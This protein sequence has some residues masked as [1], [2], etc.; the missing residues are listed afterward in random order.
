M[1]T[2]GQ[3]AKSQ[4]DPEKVEE[5]IARMISEHNADPEAHLGEGGSLRSH[6]M[7]EIIDHLARSVVRDKLLEY[8]TWKL[9]FESIDGYSKYLPG[10]AQLIPQIQA[11]VF[12]NSEV[13][14]HVARLWVGEVYN[15]PLVITKNPCIQFSMKV[16]F[17]DHTD[18]YVVWGSDNPIG[19][20]YVKYFGFKT[21]HGQP[22]KVFG[23]YRVS[24]TQEVEVEMSGVSPNQPHF[25][26]AEVLNQ[27]ATLLFYVD[28][29]LKAS[30]SPQWGSWDT[31][32]LFSI[33]LK[34]FIE[35]SV[36]HYFWNF[37]IEQDI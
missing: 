33:S 16:R 21:K 1:I 4:D 35:E 30:V 29:N 2:W 32:Y 26:R 10:T 34:T 28:G 15:V 13:L 24:S 23:C 37:T 5:A 11:L 17:P 8:Q 31:D 6:K 14:N 25:Y 18:V 19:N 7:A 9:S 27:G 12:L 22:Q 20:P 3:L 36:E